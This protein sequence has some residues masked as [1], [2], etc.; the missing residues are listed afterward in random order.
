MDFVVLKAKKALAMNG[1]VVLR[2]YQKAAIKAL[3]SYTY[4]GNPLIVAPTG[5]GKSHILGGFCKEVYDRWPDNNV[6]II[7]HTKEIIKQDIRILEQYL[8]NYIV[9]GHSAGI[10]RRQTRQFTVASI[11]TIYKSPALFEKYHLFIVDEAHLIPPSGEGRYRTFFNALPNIPVVGLTATPFRRGH[12]LLTENHIFDTI[13]Y[14]ITIQYLVD[15]KYLVPLSTKATEYTFND[16]GVKVLGGDFSKIDLSRRLD[17]YHITEQIVKEL[18]QF[19]DKR[20]SWLIFAIDIAHC[21]HIA[22]E[23]NKLGIVAAAVHSKLDIDRQHLLD[24]FKQKHIQALVAVE[25]LTTG[26]DAPNIDLIVLMRPT[27]SPVL[28]LSDTMNLDNRRIT[29]NKNI[30]FR[31]ME[32]K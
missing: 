8:P 26:F 9:G 29:L 24:L 16:Q 6:L 28:Q 13:V 17:H 14:D 32:I 10:N 19:K 22:E 18:I 23:L 30:I 4:E 27:Q 31:K 2:D 3:L 25:T 12:G 15:K 7:T 5:S 20:N 1:K 11:Q 21:E